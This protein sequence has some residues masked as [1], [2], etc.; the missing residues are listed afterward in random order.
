MSPRGIIDLRPGRRGAP[1]RGQQPL[2]QPRAAGEGKAPRPLSLRARRRRKRAL[3]ALV[4]L[5]LIGGAVWA[6]SFV[7]Y[8]P[9][10]TVSVISVEGAHAVSSHLVSNYVE[11]ILNDGTYHLL[12]R[13]NI[14]LY[15]WSEIEKDIVEYFPRIKSA[16]VSRESM[17][18]TTLHIVLEE[19]QPFALW[20][21]SAE[22]VKCYFMDDGGFIFAEA[23]STSTTEY[24]FRGGLA[25]STSSTSSPQAN[26]IGETFIKAH[27]PGLLTLLRSLGQA[28]FNPRG[29]AIVN[30]QD[31]SVP[32]V[33]AQGSGQAEFM[34][35]ASFGEDAGALARNLGLVL[36]SDPLKEKEDQ[37]EYIDLRFGN[38]VYYR[39]KGGAQV[40][41]TNN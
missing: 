30:E 31:F 36:S 35:K 40:E 41:S 21:S 18:S 26:P 16:S 8:L 28:G 39:L 9:R 29:A 1:P 19:R 27:L 4:L 33:S 13:S 11:S 5:A 14:F 2:F 17:L 34:L 37:I 23:V 12:S 15:P 32:L 10:F 22:G 38:R 24:V 6:V 20:C 3:I 7:S 25:A